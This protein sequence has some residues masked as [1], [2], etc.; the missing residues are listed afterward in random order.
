MMDWM[1]QRYDL[2]WCAPHFPTPL[3]RVQLANF[4]RLPWPVRSDGSLCQQEYSL[5]TADIG[6]S[7]CYDE[8]QWARECEL[9]GADVSIGMTF[10]NFCTLYTRYRGLKQL[11]R[12]YNC[13]KKLPR[14]AGRAGWVRGRFPGGHAPY[15]YETYFTGKSSGR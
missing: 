15:T 8:A 12:D 9:L 6:V 13:V 5:F 3:G 2:D 11:G 4:S 7:H 14:W 10:R 1:F